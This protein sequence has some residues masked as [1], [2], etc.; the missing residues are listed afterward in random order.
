MTDNY[1]ID[2]NSKLFQ[3][4]LNLKNNKPNEPAQERP[5]PAEHSFQAK[6]SSKPAPHSHSESPYYV[7]PHGK[8][9]EKAQLHVTIGDIEEAASLSFQ[10]EEHPASQPN[11]N[12]EYQSMASARE[13]EPIREEFEM[14]MKEEYCSTKLQ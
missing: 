5:L 7:P 9:N 6:N 12:E 10:E 8:A 14:T 1:Q 2:K 3:K 13:P 11:K 4:F